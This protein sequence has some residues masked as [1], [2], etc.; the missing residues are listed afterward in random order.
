MFLPTISA[1]IGN[2]RAPRSISAATRYALGPANPLHRFHRRANRPAAKNYIVDQHDR[3][4]IDRRM[5]LDRADHRSVSLLPPIIAIRRDVDHGHR[6]RES[7]RFPQSYGPSAAPDGPRGSEC[8][9]APIRQAPRISR[10]SRAPSDGR[11]WR[12]RRARAEFSLSRHKK[13]P[14]R[15]TGRVYERI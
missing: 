10:R 6:R 1:R 2:S 9:S 13:R 15:I 12:Y 4:V 7:C 14:S 8:R 5:N 3:F 11:L